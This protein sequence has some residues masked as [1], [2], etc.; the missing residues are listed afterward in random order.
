MVGDGKPADRSTETFRV[1]VDRHKSM[2]FSIA[3]R[4]LG[5]YGIAEEVAQDVFLELYRWLDRLE[6]EAHVTFWLRRTASHRATDAIRRRKLRPEAAAEEWEESFD[7][8]VLGGSGVGRGKEGS[9]SLSAQLERALLTL[10]ESQRAAV[11]LRYQEDLSPDEIAR[12]TGDTVP[13][14]KSN[15]QRGMALLRRKS[16]VLLKEFVR[17]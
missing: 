9:V 13:A 15:L 6:S 11:V 3:Y 12:V 10:P 16:E 1:L 17:A 14:V 4:M 2:V 5:D 7:R 8:A